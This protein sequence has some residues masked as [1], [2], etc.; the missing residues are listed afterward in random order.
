M[1]IQHTAS[2]TR[3]RDRQWLRVSAELTAFAATATGRRGIT[4]AAAPG[5]AHGH[6][7]CFIPARALIEIDTDVCFPGIDPAGIN[8]ANPRDHGNYAPAIGV[9]HHELAHAEHSRWP[10]PG[11]AVPGLVHRAAMLLEEIR[12]EHLRLSDR[13][14]DRPWLMAAA[15]T[16]VVPTLITGSVTRYPAWTAAKAALLI[17]GRRDAGVLDP[18]DVT[19]I[20]RQLRAALSA[21]LLR[22]LRRVWRRVLHIGDTD[23]AGMYRLAREWCRILRGADRAGTVDARRAAEA[24]GAAIRAVRDLIPPIPGP[25]PWE[26]ERPDPDRVFDRRCPFPQRPPTPGIE[27]A[28]REL[29]RRLERLEVT[30]REPVAR[31]SALPPGR[32]RMRGALGASAQRAAGARVTAQPWQ[33]VTRIRP[34]APRP[35]I[36][37]AL[38]VSVSMGHF[39]TPAVEAAWMCATAARYAHGESAAVTFGEFLQPLVAPGRVPEG[40]AVP[41]MEYSTR[42]LDVAAEALIRALRLS[43]PGDGRVLFLITDGDV[44]SGEFQLVA[45]KVAALTRAGCAVVQ[46]APPDSLWIPRAASILLDAPDRLPQEITRAVIAAM[47]GTTS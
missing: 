6:P 15:A 19:A 43:A 44:A 8:A 7:A 46:I 9:L 18:C 29:A 12:A 40:L 26:P 31:S 10:R 42:F 21:H 28:S 11:T 22:R 20:G 17:L 36:G 13:G 4:V 35:R 27:R 38:D 2:R 32:L 45:E 25:P 33:R 23:A 37:I 5:L 24:A 30:Q 3:G 14:V 1:H 41:A 34:P 16:I 47:R 39:F